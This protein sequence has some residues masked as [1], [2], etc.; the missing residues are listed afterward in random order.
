MMV[1]K[2]KIVGIA[3]SRINTIFERDF[4]IYDERI[5]DINNTEFY[6]TYAIG[7][8]PFEVSYDKSNEYGY[9]IYAYDSKDSNANYFVGDTRTI[10]LVPNI[11]KPLIFLNDDGS[12]FNSQYKEAY[13]NAVKYDG[14]TSKDEFT[15]KMIEKG[16][17]SMI[18]SD[19]HGLHL[20]LFYNDPELYKIKSDLAN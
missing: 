6:L 4:S 1:A 10:K 3:P 16:F 8:N 14:V 19:I 13:D 18:I 15:K 20:V 9:G 2:D 7:N 12:S 11:K 5:L 17:D